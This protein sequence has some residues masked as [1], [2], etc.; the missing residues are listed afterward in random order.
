M[1]HRLNAQGVK[2]QLEPAAAARDIIAAFRDCDGDATRVATHFD[3]DYR[4]LYRWIDKLDNDGVKVDRQGLTMRSKIEAIRQR[5]K[6]KRE[7]TAA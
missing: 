4:T 6:A 2:V 7:R 5:A 3:V 1:A